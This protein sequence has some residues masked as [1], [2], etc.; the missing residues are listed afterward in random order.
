[1]YSQRILKLGA[2]FEGRLEAVFLAGALDYVKYNEESL[3]LEI[4]CEHICEYDVALSVDEFKEIQELA[5]DM[6]FELGNAP[7]K[8][9][10]ALTKT[11]E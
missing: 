8:Y 3:A 1:M 4:F 2:K 7:F 9:L 5:L 11:E 6:G 10:Q